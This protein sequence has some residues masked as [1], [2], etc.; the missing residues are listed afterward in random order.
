[1]RTPIARGKAVV[2]DLYGVHSVHLMAMA[3]RESCVAPVLIY[4][5]IFVFI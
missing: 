5:L 4:Q 2:G 1:V 3:Q